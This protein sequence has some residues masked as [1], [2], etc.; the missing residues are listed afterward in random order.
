MA[1][2]NFKTGLRA[3]Y[4]ALAVKDANTLYWLSDTQELFKGD[5]L[6]G[7]GRMATADG[8]GLMSAEDKA[9]VQTLV[10]S[11]ILDLAPV[12][13]SIVVSDS[14]DGK[15]IGVQISS[16]ADNALQLAAN[17][18]KVVVPAA[19]EYE[20][21]Q[22]PEADAGYA[23]T[24]Y[25]AKD[26]VQ[27]G[28]AMNIPKDYLVKSA[29]LKTVETADVPYEGAAVG[30][31]YIDFVVN[32]KDSSETE[33][34]IYLAVNDLIDVY[35]GGDGI[36][37]TSGVVSVKIDASAAN[38]LVATGNGL[39]LNLATASAA[40]ALSA[41]G[42]AYIDSLPAVL[43]NKTTRELTGTNGKALVFNE[44][45]GGGAKFEHID[46][47]WSFVGVNDG[48][49]NGITGQLYSVKQEGGKYVGTR[50]NM[51]SNG[52][53]YLP[54]SNSSA[55]TAADEIATKGD[56]DDAIIDALTWEDM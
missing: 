35:V 36:D 25:L 52:F 6:Y 46:G 19:A 39:G 2:V 48:G 15:L 23:A 28:A 14:E 43:A 56:I 42:K 45:D 17:G 55:Y 7:I 3:K 32:T 24:Y 38:G 20:I 9:Y 49:E 27:V 4:D 10:E 18:L 33:T 47:T 16:D 51:T 26:G 11:G 29:E 34:H 31:K 13:A 40:G 41:T 1:K 21:V 12:D 5:A 22:K 44:S 53:F 8:A 37:I 30:D 54:N 50:L